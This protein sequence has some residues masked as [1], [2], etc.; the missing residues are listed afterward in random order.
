ML[1]ALFSGVW[2]SERFD[3]VRARGGISTGLHET[4][5]ILLGLVSRSLPFAAIM[6]DKE[7]V[8]Y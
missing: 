3:F 2:E 5:G 7:L 6:A 4:P 1:P 8:L